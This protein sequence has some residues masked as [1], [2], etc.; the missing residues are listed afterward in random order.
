MEENHNT[1]QHKE[2]PTFGKLYCGRHVHIL[3][4]HLTFQKKCNETEVEMNVGELQLGFQDE[5]QK[6]TVKSEIQMGEGEG[7]CRGSLWEHRVGC[8]FF[9]FLFLICV[10]DLVLYSAFC[11]GAQQA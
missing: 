2:T 10:F 6:C 4:F 5:K 9:F 3:I 11:E 7:S 8:F 1:T